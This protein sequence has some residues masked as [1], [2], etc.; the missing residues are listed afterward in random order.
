LVAKEESDQDEDNSEEDQEND[1]DE[2]EDQY[3]QDPTEENRQKAKMF[4]SMSFWSKSY[5]TEV[6][7]DQ[8]KEGDI[9][10]VKALKSFGQFVRSTTKFVVWAAGMVKGSQR[11]R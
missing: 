6:H 8:L 3:Q 4:D 11:R 1:D 7:V 5:H 2:E 10:S 9:F